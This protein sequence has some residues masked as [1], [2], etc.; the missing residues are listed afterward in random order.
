MVIDERKRVR[1]RKIKERDSAKQRKEKQSLSFVCSSEWKVKWKREDWGCYCALYH[2]L[3]LSLSFCYYCLLLLLLLLLV[4][5]RATTATQHQQ[6]HSSNILCQAAK[7]GPKMLYWRHKSVFSYLAEYLQAKCD[8]W[9]C[10]WW[11]CCRRRRRC[12]Y[13]CC[14]YSC[15][16]VQL[17]CVCLSVCL[18]L[19]LCMCVCSPNLNVAGR[20]T[21]TH[22]HKTYTHTHRD[23]LSLTHK[24]K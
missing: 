20:H 21:H 15:L 11:C 5:A 8:G 23:S 22:R 24:G 12:C 14:C 3:S 18:Y 2:C 7:C 13:C 17:F 19:Y 16:S 4:F 9:W 10:R 1:G 6:Q